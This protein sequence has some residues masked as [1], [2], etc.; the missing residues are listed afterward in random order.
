MPTTIKKNTT[1]LTQRSKI[2]QLI[3]TAIEDKKGDNITIIDLRKI[4]DSITDFMIICSA[5]SSHQLRAIAYHIEE[6]VKQTLKENPYRRN[7]IQTDTWLIL[8]YV[9]VIV[10]LMHPNSRT[11]YQ[12]EEM[13]SDAKITNLSK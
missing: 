1:R 4:K 11:Y 5:T 2:I 12:L 13:W 9:H 10:H 8:D 6:L 7:G 3:I